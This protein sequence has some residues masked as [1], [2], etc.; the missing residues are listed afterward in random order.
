MP[1]WHEFTRDWRENGDLQVV[2]IVQEQHPDRARLFAQ[3]RQ[4]DFP[5]LWDPFNLTGSKVV[6]NVVAVDEAGVVRIV[7]PKQESFEWDFLATDFTDAEVVEAAAQTA[8]EP[9]RAKRAQAE[10]E[11]LR[12]FLARDGKRLDVPLRELGELSETAPEDAALAFRLGVASR[13]RYD[14]ANPCP[15]DF[16]DALDRWGAALD[17]DPNQYIW[18]RRIQQYGP[19]MDKPYDFYGW[20]ERATGEVRQRGEEPIV[21][22]TTLTPAELAQPARGASSPEAVTEPDPGGRVL[23]DDGLMRVEAAVAPDS[24]GKRPLASVHLT[25]RPDAK[26]KAHWTNGLTPAQV[27][28]DTPE[29]WS[30]DRA[31]RELAEPDSEVS[32]EARVV[33][34]EVR[35][36]EG[37]RS[38]KL[39]GYALFHVCE[40]VNGACT[41]LRRDFEVVAHL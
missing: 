39:T 28:L 38:G 19:R 24:S 12:R 31:L 10:A 37:T 34:F 23:R 13:M 7:N 21:L 6:P 18:R 9:A 36:P 4:L 1:V 26:R 33:T 25:L 30:V 27:W 8:A 16:Q 17:L 32:N 11:L 41:Y 3:W 2:G 22:P 15:T 5:I 35:A 29:G 20:V 40:D 14:S